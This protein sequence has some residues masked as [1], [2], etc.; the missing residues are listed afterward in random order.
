MLFFLWYNIIGEIM[1]IKEYFT[2][3]KVDDLKNEDGIFIGHGIIAVIDGVTSK[4]S[5]LYKGQKSGKIAKDIILKALENLKP[6]H[7]CEQALLYINSELNRY[8]KSLGQNNEWFS[9]QIIIYNDH[10]KEIWNFE[11]VTV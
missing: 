3:G 5:N 10:Y 1:I 8:H 9:A 7:T 11:I 4:T 6:E 2:R